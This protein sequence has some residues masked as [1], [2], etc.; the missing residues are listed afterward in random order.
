MGR[1]RACSPRLGQGNLHKTLSIAAVVKSILLSAPTA[2][3]QT[4]PAPGQEAPPAGEESVLQE[5][6]VTGTTSKDRTLLSASADI[7]PISD[8]ELAIKAPRSTDEVLEMIPGMFVEA[9]AGAVSNNYSVR[10][11][12]GGGQSFIS[13]EEDGLPVIY[14]GLNPDELFSNDIT[15]DRVEAV[16]GGSSGILT[17]NGA[18]A[19]I[20]FISR[21]PSFER[22]ES[23]FRLSATTYREERADFYYSAPIT[24]DLAFNVGGYVD[25][26]RGTRDAGLT[27]QTYHVKGALEKRWDDGAYIRLGGKIGNQHD[28]YYA[29]MPFRFGADGKPRDAPGLDSLNDNI[30]GPA[31][32]NIGVP[33][34]CATGNCIRTFSLAQGIY[35]QTSQIRLDAEVPIPNGV[36]LF[37]K[38]HYLDYTWDFNGV[39]PGSGTGNAGLTTAANYLNGG[40]DSPIASLLALG[41]AAY[42]GATQFAFHDLTTGQIISASDTAALNALNG[43]GLMQ[44]TWLNK[45]VVRG[46]DLA[47]N[48]GARWESGW[49]SVKNSLTGGG[50]YFVVQRYNDQS[51]VSH[52]INGVTAQSHIYDVVPLNSA[53]RV[54]GSLT[55]NG[56][57]SYGDWGTGIWKDRTTSFSTYVN[58]ELTLF[59]KWHVDFGARNENMHD[60]YFNGNTATGPVPAGSVGTGLNPVA[61]LFDGTYTKASKKYNHTAVTAGLNYTFTSNFS[62][63]VRYENGFQMNP[64]GGA[65]SNGPTVIT[66]EEG[67]L[68]YQGYGL[69]STLVYFHT[70]FN[71]QSYQSPDPVNQAIL[72]TFT[73]DLRTNGVELDVAYAPIPMFRIDAFGVYQRPETASAQINGVAKPEFNGRTTPHTPKLL[74]TI[75]P[76]FVFPDGK[77]QLYARFKYIGALYADAGNGLSL[78]GYGVVTVGATYNVTENLNVNVSADNL[79]NEIGLTEGNPRQGPTQTVANGF[80]YGRS[81]AGR[82]ALLSITY[83]F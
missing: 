83:R 47:G 58:D 13:F 2:M 48:F 63:Y 25:S 29:D 16:R 57:V 68:R 52:V 44:Q 15:I 72:D 37:A 39:F 79:T 36:T 8:A 5:V 17:P 26:T 23:L 10:G 50:M 77:G 51:A 41:R 30:A 22:P 4:A 27:Y 9:T 53:G 65:P 12:S 61:N 43:N 75:Q 1:K 54:V 81:I 34:S 69:V 59:D 64:G 49:S 67:G 20:N 76:A 60:D 18:A 19:T 82:N 73:A 40:A 71:N 62:A 46:H 33:D 56:L 45:Q 21:R 7:T 70:D 78:P 11:L 42:P 66:L 55:D 35:A 6:V 31:F 3:A 24:T 32:A 80:F 74:Y 38:A 14:G 28:P